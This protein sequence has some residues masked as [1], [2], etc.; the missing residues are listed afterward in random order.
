MTGYR[1]PMTEP[2]P[3]RSMDHLITGGGG[4]VGAALARELIARGRSVRCLD[5]GGFERLDDLVGHPRLELLAGDA[6]DEQTVDRMVG[7]CRSVIHAAAVVGV[8]IY[9]QDPARVLD[10]NIGATRAVAAACQR[11][12]RPLLFTSSSEVYGRTPWDLSENAGTAIGPSSRSR[13]CYALSKAVGEQYVHALARDGLRFVT[14]RY[15]N[16]YGPRMDAPGEGRV[17]SKFLGY[18]QSGEPLPLV[19]GGDAVR[20]FCYIDDA[21]AATLTLFDAVETGS[22]VAGQAFNVGGDEPVTI[23]QLAER[24]VALAGHAPGTVDVA[25]SEFFGAGFEEIPRRVPRFDALERATGFVAHVP[26][27]EGLRRTLAWWK[28]LAEGDPTIDRRTGREDIALIRPRIEPDAALVGALIGSLHSGHVTNNGPHLRALERELGHWLDVAEPVVVSSGSAAM[29]LAAAALGRSGKAILPA[30]TYIA[31]LNA[32]VHA[33]LQPIFCDIDPHT[34]TL[35]PGHLATLLSAHDDVGL[36][37]PVNVYGVHPDLSAIGALCDAAGA[38]VL[39][40]NAHG[41]GAE[42]A[43][44]RCPDGP[45]VSIVSLHGTKICPAVEGGAV[46]SDD[47]DLLVEMRR[48]RAHGLASDMLQSTPGFNL[49]MSELHAAVGRHSLRGLGAAVTR[50]R[51]YGERLRAWL[52]E[53]CGDAWQ[54]QRVPADQQTNFQFLGARWQH[55]ARLDVDGVIASLADNGVQ[56]RRFFWPPLHELAM[57]SGRFDLPVTRSVVEELLCLP[58]HNRMTRDELNRIAHAARLVSLAHASP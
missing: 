55:S 27:D 4:F 42:L 54:V 31:T 5:T 33:G 40:D 45:R 49:K 15:F 47:A 10:V 57:Y 24:V 53:R 22:K 19:D 18:L 58:I 44:Q 36:V 17:L 2:V 1:R 38:D 35:D 26:L 39:Y 29:S 46:L 41:I 34:W 28:L 16:V 52:L 13:W 51:D 7:A 20:A 12:D 21:V 11:H 50:R 56:G 32:V 48:L 37:L 3:L 6:T 8:D 43:G 25:G 9:V 14:V 30:F 23:R